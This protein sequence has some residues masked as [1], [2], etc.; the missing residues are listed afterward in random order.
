MSRRKTRMAATRKASQK[1]R[2]A[3]RHA[4]QA[5]RREFDRRRRAALWLKRQAPD[6]VTLDT[7]VAN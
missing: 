2:M 5:A 1:S 3:P 4:A 6:L 7:A